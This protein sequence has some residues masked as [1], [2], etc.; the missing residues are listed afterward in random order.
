MLPA[1][2][3]YEKADLNSTDMHSFI[4]PLAPAVPPCWESKSDWEIFRLVAK[5]VTELSAKHL[6][7]EI[8]DVVASPLAHDTAAE[9]AQPEPK[10]W[11]LGEV[12]AIPGR[13]MPGLKVVRRDYANLLRR[14]CALGPLVRSGGLGA[15]GTHYKVE[16]V[17][18][19][20]VRTGP[21]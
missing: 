21:K 16:D 7:G 5:R 11:I 14:F 19:E 8:L 3:W 13:S 4:H 10:D 18:D 15:H 6:P 20:M 12:E 9:I 1:A 17:Y 2:T